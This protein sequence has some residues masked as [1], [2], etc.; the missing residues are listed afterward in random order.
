MDKNVAGM[1]KKRMSSR[2]CLVSGHL[3]KGLLE[4]L[5]DGLVLLL[6]GDQL[7]LQ[8]VHLGKDEMIAFENKTRKAGT[9]FCSFWTDFSANSARA[10]ACFSLE[11]KVLICSL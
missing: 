5:S 11:L 1:Q 9:S 6:L 2:H 8:P 3:S 7:I 4:L 10:S